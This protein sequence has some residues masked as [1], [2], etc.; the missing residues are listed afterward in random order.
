METPFF[1]YVLYSPK[2]GKTYAGFT[3]DLGARVASH[4]GLAKKGWTARFRPWV[5]VYYEAFQTK[6]EAM[7]R[8]KFLKSGA[9]REF[10]KK[11]ILPGFPGKTGTTGTGPTKP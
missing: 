3:S 1:A 5:L 6:R 8:E 4:N 9:G 10:I 11:N 7:A 2:H